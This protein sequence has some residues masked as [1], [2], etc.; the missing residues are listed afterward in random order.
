MY[1]S[2]D[3]FLYQILTCLGERHLSELTG[4]KNEIKRTCNPF[5]RKFN[6]PFDKKDLKNYSDTSVASSTVDNGIQKWV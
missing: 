4:Q 6:N 3:E 2:V 5:E 1:F